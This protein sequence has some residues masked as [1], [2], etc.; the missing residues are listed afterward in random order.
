MNAVLLPTGTSAAAGSS[1]LG[2]G[3]HPGGARPA[4]LQFA[5]RDLKSHVPATGRIPERA[6]S[7]AVVANIVKDHL[8]LSH[9]GLDEA[10]RFICLI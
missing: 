5:M 7:C 3:A 10:P 1:S 9:I 6:G 8:Y 2:P 4:S